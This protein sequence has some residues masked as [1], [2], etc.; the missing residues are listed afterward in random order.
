MPKQ[1]LL[2]AFI[3]IL[4][5]ISSLLAI[6][7]EQPKWTRSAVAKFESHSKKPPE[8]SADDVI[9]WLAG[10]FPDSGEP[11]DEVE[12]PPVSDIATPPKKAQ[13]K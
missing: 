1:F 4:I 13:D 8:E 7:S 3:C 11:F 5:M 12:E 10:L 2:Y 6:R 9:E